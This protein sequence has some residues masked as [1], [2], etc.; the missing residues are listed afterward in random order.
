M[1]LDYTNFLRP[2]ADGDRYI[3]VQQNGT[4]IYTINPFSIENIY[5]S[6][7]L[8]K[9]N[10]KSNKLITLDFYNSVQSKV[11][12]VSL[13]TQIDT[14]RSNVPYN[15]SK[16]VENYVENQLDKTKVKGGTFSGR[17]LLSNGTE[18]G[19]T[20]SPSFLYNNGKLTISQ[21]TNNGTIYVAEFKGYSGSQFK[22]GVSSDA[23]FGIANDVVNYGGTGYSPYNLTAKEISFNI[24]NDPV[25]K[26][27]FKI[28]NDGSLTFNGNLNPGASLT[29]SLG[30]SSSRW[31]SIYVKD[32]FA[33]SQSLYLGGVKISSNGEYIV[34]DKFKFN[35]RFDIGSL[36]VT[37]DSV[38]SGNP[39]FNGN[40]V[41]QSSLTYSLG[42]TSS[43]WNFLHTNE[44]NVDHMVM[45]D[46]LITA[47]NSNL[48][49]NGGKVT[50]RY[51]ATSSTPLQVPQ[52][53]FP[54]SLDVN[55][56]LSL[57]PMQSVMVFNTLFN[58][59]M[60][61][62]YVEGD[63][64][65]GF[66]GRIDSYDPNTGRL[67]LITETSYGYGL[68]NSSNEVFTYSFW[69]INL[70][71]E[72]GEQGSVV[73]PNVASYSILL[74]DGISSVTA[75]SNLRFTDLNKLKIIGTTELQQII[76]VINNGDSG[77]TVNYDYNNGSI[78]VHDQNLS[79][80]YT[81]NFI[82][83]PDYGMGEF[84]A[85][86]LTI[87]INQSTNAWIP[88]VF[89]IGGTPITV[90]WGNGLEP[91][92]NPN[93]VDVIGLTLLSSF[94]CLGNFTSFY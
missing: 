44:V 45:Q 35:S 22:I 65:I 80:D 63:E 17:V 70:I 2:L 93:Q 43:K 24:V 10:L 54:I 47:S 14:L 39:I 12:L 51:S 85:I 73:L 1:A 18:F 57:T 69:Y 29:Y 21:P 87:V 36:S 31:D 20:T 55:R 62:N 74:S 33:A 15:V 6:A 59:Y 46:W 86:T 82:N 5:V 89:Q 41:P 19:A 79:Q 53:G 81:A 83:L 78:W 68:T 25:N 37:N 61:D 84:K 9:V 11:A 7:N 27:A 72:K 32:V 52:V 26:T 34:T 92:G 30:S 71:G 67:T 56:Y 42:S 49:I 88:T 8:V 23:D 48:Y 90:K 75:S 64:S 3:Q 58:N 16:D 4:V 66:S 91:T 38:I 76:E 60:V 50:D 28:E 94:I 13:Q 77:S 40:L